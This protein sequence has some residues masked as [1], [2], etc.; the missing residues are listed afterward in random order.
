MAPEQWERPKE[1]DHRADIYSLGV[2]FYEMLTGELPMGKFEPPSAKAR[3]DVRIDDVVMRAIERDRERRWQHAS[4]VKTQ[5]GVISA[6]AAVGPAPVAA[7]TSATAAK[8]VEIPS[9][10][11]VVVP[12]LV[13][14]IATVAAFIVS[15][16]GWSVLC[17]AF[18][19][20]CLIGG[21]VKAIQR[22]E[23]MRRLG[24]VKPKP[25][26]EEKLS[27]KVRKEKALE[28]IEAEAEP[29]PRG[30]WLPGR[31]VALVTLAGI[32]A[33][34]ALCGGFG[35]G[36]A[37]MTVSGILFVL[38]LV[39]WHQYDERK[40]A[41]VASEKGEREHPGPPVAIEVL[42]AVMI[43]VGV[44]GIGYAMFGHHEADDDEEG[45]HI[46][47]GPF[48]IRAS[49]K[50]A[51][52]KD[53][54]KEASADR[55]PWE[56]LVEATSGETPPKA[57][58]DAQRQGI[59]KMWTKA[60]ALQSSEWNVGFGNLYPNEDFVML[61]AMAAERRKASADEGLLGVPLF[62]RERAQ[63]GKFRIESARLG[64]WDGRSSFTSAV[65]RATDDEQS[66]RF[67]MTVQA[68]VWLFAAAPVELE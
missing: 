19:A 40:K 67:T 57:Q 2:V 52:P 5:M 45:T 26:E 18:A 6:G 55:A 36:P 31:T 65:V 1:V 23:T 50:A 51:K 43:V 22:H 17:S 38:G 14:V 29:E 9:L 41:V 3:V 42:S 15:F 48:G 63:L 66:L 34:A 62:P 4:E 56:F 30:R 46:K 11:P 53:P 68:G 32:L 64:G 39:L 24:L 58:L 10:V 28:A 37:G 47:I 8:D 13:A 44:V 61:G 35:M 59:W 27:E 21:V 7:A 25:T 20:L 33:A 54:P 16:K 60:Q 49:S 12:F